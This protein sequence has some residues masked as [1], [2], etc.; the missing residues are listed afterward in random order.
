MT[1]SIVARCPSTGQFGVA[2]ATGTPGVGTL[3]TWAQPRGG[4]WTS[5]SIR[6]GT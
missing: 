6:C 3:L 4:P 1:L 2:A 5:R